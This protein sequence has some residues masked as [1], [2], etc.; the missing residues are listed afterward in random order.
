MTNP[1]TQ[2]TNAATGTTAYF[3]NDRIDGYAPIPQGDGLP[4][5]T[6]LYLAGRDPFVINEPPEVIMAAIVQA[7]G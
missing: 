2:I 1:T 7:G 6:E 4:C 5:K 3:R